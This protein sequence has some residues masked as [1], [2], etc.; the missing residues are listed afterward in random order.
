MKPASNLSPQKYVLDNVKVWQK[1]E[2]LIDDAY[3][4]F[5]GTLGG[6]NRN[7]LTLKIYFPFIGLQCPSKN[8]HE[9][10]LP[11]TILPHKGVHFSPIDGKGYPIKRLDTGKIL[12]NVNHPKYFFSAHRDLH[13]LPQTPGLVAPG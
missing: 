8:F 12:G 1:I 4:L 5:P 13:N 9:C 10:R 6:R 11:C 7:L 2:L 3:A